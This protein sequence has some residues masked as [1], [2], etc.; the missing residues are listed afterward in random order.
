MLTKFFDSA[1]RIRQLTDSPAGTIFEGFAQTLFQSGYA[2]VTAQYHFRAVEHFVS[3]ADRVG[4]P[5]A[6]LT[7]QSR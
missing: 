5:V 6:N 2:R 4:I 7:E 3:W 1:V